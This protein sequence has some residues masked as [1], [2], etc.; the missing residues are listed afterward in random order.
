MAEDA[1]QGYTRTP[2]SKA[3]SYEFTLPAITVSS[4]IRLVNSLWKLDFRV[5]ES[6]RHDSCC[7]LHP[8]FLA[9][10]STTAEACELLVLRLN[11]DVLVCTLPLVSVDEVGFHLRAPVM[12]TAPFGSHHLYYGT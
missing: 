4:I 9:S 8:P 12:S 7:L 6:L 10:A 2:S 5:S 11:V 1:R 3:K